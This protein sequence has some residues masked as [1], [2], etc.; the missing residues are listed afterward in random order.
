MTVSIDQLIARSRHPRV[1]GTG[2]MDR[3]SRRVLRAYDYWDSKRCGR[4]LPDRADIDPT[5]IPDL[6]PFVVLTDVLTEPPYL[7]Y[8]LVG[9][10]QVKV[11]GLDPTGQPV[12]GNHIG[13]HLSEDTADEVILNYRIVIEKKLPV[14]DY[15][16][17]VGPKLEMG[18][19]MRG[20]VRER[21]TLLLPLSQGG[22]SAVTQV[23]CIADVDPAD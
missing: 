18:S 14:Y 12:R 20:Q 3:C 1:I 7:R 6:L 2:F 21:G 16:T 23:F 13:H 22:G 9:T 5:E 8:R 15:N 17:V 4:P 19:L 11:R 10:Q